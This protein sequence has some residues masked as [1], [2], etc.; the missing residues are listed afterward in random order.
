MEA[1]FG[2]GGGMVVIR[3]VSNGSI[4]LSHSM[5]KSEAK[6]FAEALFHWSQLANDQERVK[7]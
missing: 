4:V 1:H 2:V 3:Y 7:E 5:T 6:T